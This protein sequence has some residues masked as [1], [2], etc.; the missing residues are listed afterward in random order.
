M[1]F[2]YALVLAALASTSV[3]ANTNL[4]LHKP[5]PITK[6]DPKL[7]ECQKAVQSEIMNF[8]KNYSAGKAKGLI[9]PKEEASL[10]ASHAKLKGM[11]KKIHEDGKVTPAECHAEL[12][13]AR[14]DS[15]KLA[16]ALADKGDNGGKVIKVGDLD[17]HKKMPPK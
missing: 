16:A 2:K 3:F 1:R 9:G 17:P 6:K 4:L 14:A 8:E 7:A 13:A 12:A 11:D 5:F 10:N 15:S